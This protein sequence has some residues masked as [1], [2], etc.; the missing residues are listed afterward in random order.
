MGGFLRWASLAY[1][2]DVHKSPIEPHHWIRAPLSFP[3]NG[4]SRVLDRGLSLIFDVRTREDTLTQ[5]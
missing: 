4:S 2:L 3:P 1:G 5:Q